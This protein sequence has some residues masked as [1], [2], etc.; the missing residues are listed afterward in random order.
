[1]GSMV[2]NADGNV[3]MTT[4]AIE[5]KDANVTVL[6]EAAEV[7]VLSSKAFL[8]AASTVV[9]GSTATVILT[10][11]QGESLL[12]YIPM[13]ASLPLGVFWAH[14][15]T[16]FNASYKFASYGNKT[17]KRKLKK[18]PGMRQHLKRV[19]V[20]ADFRL[21]DQ[22]VSTGLRGSAY[23]AINVEES[24]VLIDNKVYIEQR[25]KPLPHV[26]WD[27]T[28]DDIMALETTMTMTELA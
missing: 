3:S 4:S 22:I 25:I 18:S 7:D 15:L 10:V 6:L 5:P 11:I 27:N 20:N 26:L 23:A 14:M 8:A 19:D 17:S 12:E 2:E 16:T 21:E 28:F 13:I 1:M 24:F 9:I